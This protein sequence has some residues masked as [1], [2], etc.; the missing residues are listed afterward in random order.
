MR[1]G[2]NGG[3]AASLLNR[4]ADGSRA[5]SMRQIMTD[6]YS[7]N[8]PGERHGPDAAVDLRAMTAGHDEDL[9]AWRMP[10]FMAPINT[11]VVRRSNALLG[12][13]YG[14]DFRYDEAMDMGGGPAGWMKASL[15]AFVS[16]GLVRAL[17]LGPTRWLLTQA[18][19]KPGEGPS[20][21]MRRTGGYELLFI[22]ELA[23]GE[24]RLRVAGDGDPNTEST[25]K[26]T[27]EAALCLSQDDLELS[28]G[29][30]T[31]ASAL[32]DA[33]VK[34]VREHDVLRMDLMA[35]SGAAVHFTTAPTTRPEEPLE[36]PSAT[37]AFRGNHGARQDR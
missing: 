19:P 37:Q 17:G 24:L 25:S 31:P 4:N 9:S 32:G 22:G 1:G 26:L 7:L 6:P 12:Y 35:A 28:G 10:F 20:D 36:P 30:W 23:D 3:T 15:G 18:L 16:G 34:R 29:F 13:P 21:E 27:A 11:K 33:L 2:L 5:A 14:R 8:P